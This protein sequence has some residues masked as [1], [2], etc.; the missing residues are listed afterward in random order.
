MIKLQGRQSK[1]ELSYGARG[2]SAY[3]VAVD[4]GFEGTEKEWL[5]SLIGA[6]GAPGP[7]GPMGPAG[8]DGKDGTM[9]FEELTEEEKASLK[10]EPGPKG[11]SYVLTEADKAEIASMVEVGTDF[12][13]GPGL[14]LDEDG[15]LGIR[16]G[17]AFGIG[18]E[19]ELT[20]ESYWIRHE[21]RSIGDK[22]NDLQNSIE[23]IEKRDLYRGYDN[24]WE[25]S[26]I[27]ASLEILHGPIHDGLVNE[28]RHEAEFEFN[29]YGE[30]F[31]GGFR[32]TLFREV[33]DGAVIY[34]NH[35]DNFE[36]SDVQL[37]VTNRVVRITTINEGIIGQ[38]IF[39]LF[40][41]YMEVA[42]PVKRIETRD[43]IW[44][45]V[46]DGGAFVELGIQRDYIE[47]I[48]DERI[49]QFP[50][51]EEVSV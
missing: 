50:I 13:P 27:V 45:N 10:G 42:R 29:F 4:N 38:E 11:D 12:H 40:V 1:V 20:T 18:P 25:D 9:K 35:F 36:Y 7:M 43:G 46:N 17:E 39:D 49:N 5:E 33:I 2:K 24:H 30:E 51:A 14:Y 22:L 3:Q 23:G 6:D 8:K 15:Q 48:V 16:L 41:N 19:G 26:S 31:G 37:D 47:G 32:A 44:M 21:D 28:E 34:S